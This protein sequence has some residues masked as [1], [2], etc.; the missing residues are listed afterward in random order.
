MSPGCRPRCPA[1]SAETSD[2]AAPDFEQMKAAR[3]VGWN[4]GRSSGRLSH[5]PG[6]AHGF[7]PLAAAICSRAGAY[8][9]GSGR[10]PSASSSHSNFRE[11]VGVIVR[12]ETASPRAG[13]FIDEVG[14]QRRGF[15]NGSGVSAS[16]ETGASAAIILR[17]G[18]DPRQSG[19]GSSEY[20]ASSS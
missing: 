9:A 16:P 1:S 17:G 6:Q 3:A 10:E 11:D 4:M 18:G 20:V 12:F 13:E 14:C 15:G 2:P 19:T 7:G 8:D 5:D